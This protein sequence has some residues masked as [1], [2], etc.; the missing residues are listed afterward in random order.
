[1]RP[2]SAAARGPRAVTRTIAA[3]AV[4]AAT[5]FGA[6]WAAAQQPAPGGVALDSLRLDGIV[7]W[8]APGSE[9][10]ARSLARATAGAP[11]LPAIPAEV[12]EPGVDVYLAPDERAFAEL[13]GGSPPEWGAGIAVLGAGED[14][15]V[16]PA[17][18]TA[19]V[20]PADLPR[21]LRHELAHV[22]LH[23]WLGDA[24]VPRWFHEGYGRWAAGELDLEAAWQLRLAFALGRAPVL[25][26][27]GL[28]WPAGEV[29][30]RVAYLLAASAIDYLVAEG[31][32][33][34]LRRLLERW[35][36]TGDLDQAMRAT[37]GVTVG[38]FEEDWRKH[39]RSRYGWALVLTHS[40]IFWT[41]AAL[42][43]V[44]LYVRRRR[45]DRVRL[46]R[47]A[48]T[49]PPDQPDW[50][51]PPPDEDADPAG[52]GPGSGPGP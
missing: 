15:I 45:R 20:R 14:R 28:D 16:L 23:R 8:Y 35:R 33:T 42:L 3:A 47:M 32:E 44:T 21:V 4:V 11:P 50:W 7:Y 17:Y 48:R 34:G 38:Q 18:A 1:M 6:T 40:A 13:S 5:L 36:A 31:G 9:R 2:R 51:N 10:I 22:A 39:V 41:I 26:S 24:R 29:N 12:L 27:L 19:R 37:Y 30:A 25:D 46:E 43:L 52:R 49:D